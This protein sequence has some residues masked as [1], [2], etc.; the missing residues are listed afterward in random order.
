MLQHY[1][2]AEGE[3]PVRFV[4]KNV[5]DGAPRDPMAQFGQRSLYSPVAPIAVLNG[6]PVAH[7]GHPPSARYHVRFL[8]G[9]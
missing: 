2:D 1:S 4:L 6:R 3:H 8:Q 9:P 7:E 5:G